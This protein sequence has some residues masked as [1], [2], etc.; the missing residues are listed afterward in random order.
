[1]K[2]P[3]IWPG[4]TVFVI[5]AGLSVRQSDLDL[6]EGQKVIA[7]NKMFE[8]LPAAPVIYFTDPRVW[9]WYKDEMAQ[10]PARIFTM[11][12]KKRLRTRRLDYIGRQRR[13]MEGLSLDP[14]K[15]CHG[16]NSGYAAINLAVLLG[17]AV[18]VLYG[19]DMGV[20]QDDGLVHCHAE[21]PVPTQPHVF[22][23]MLPNFD[24]LIAPL[25]EAGVKIINATRG[26]VLESFPRQS[27]REI[28]DEMLVPDT[29]GA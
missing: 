6:L 19:F 24:S 29:A 21:H 14:R 5:G 25:E 15:L 16:N 7:V 1:M 18:I 27:L 4:A 10:H 3:K 17:A 8:R 12:D 13:G 2:V 22:E 11:A 28:L 26:G 20:P 23:R 9:N